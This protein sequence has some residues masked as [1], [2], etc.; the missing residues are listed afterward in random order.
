MSTDNDEYWL[1][2]VRFVS[3]FNGHIPLESTNSTDQ[4]WLFSGSVSN[5]CCI[6]RC[7]SSV[8]P[9]LILMPEKSL[10]P[11]KVPAVLWSNFLWV[12]LDNWLHDNSLVQFLFNEIFNPLSNS[13][14][15]TSSFDALPIMTEIIIVQQNTVYVL[16]QDAR[17]IHF[18]LT[19]QRWLSTLM[20]VTWR[21]VQ[22]F[23]YIVRASSLPKPQL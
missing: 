5:V 7:T 12:I 3:L 13:S 20:A 4:R 15:S 11:E 18:L 19:H 6:A 8:D 16:N 9:V 21:A 23:G 22:L 14:T 17:K 10:I 1:V 2:L